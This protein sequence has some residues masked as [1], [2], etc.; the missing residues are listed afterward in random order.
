[1]H[2]ALP[3]RCQAFV[4]APSS[5]PYADS[6]ALEACLAV[7]R[8]RA[9]EGLASGL[10]APSPPAEDPGDKKKV[11]K[12][13]AGAGGPFLLDDLLAEHRGFTEANA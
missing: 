9:Q 6:I 13:P 3:G 4:K 5:Q 7:A 8:L 1:M 2:P 10:P 11:K 12:K